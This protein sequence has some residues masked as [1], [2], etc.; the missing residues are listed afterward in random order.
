MICIVVL[1]ALVYWFNWTYLPSLPCGL[2][3]CPRPLTGVLFTQ[4]VS[5]SLGTGACAFTIVNN[6]TAPLELE[7]CFMVVALSASA[8]GGETMGVNGTIGGPALT[9]IPAS[10]SAVATC[11][12]STSQLSHQDSGSIASGLFDV[13]LEKG[14]GGYPTGT[15]TAVNFYGTWSP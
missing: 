11:A 3:A 14:W 2:G 7:R 13:K 6:S 8:S 12:V 5:C 10:S 1:A 9:G 15:E 4:E